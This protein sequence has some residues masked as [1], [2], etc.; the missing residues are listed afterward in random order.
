V[1]V[2]KKIKKVVMEDN[3]LKEVK[4]EKEILVEKKKRE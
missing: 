3:I 2:R 4:E 1:V